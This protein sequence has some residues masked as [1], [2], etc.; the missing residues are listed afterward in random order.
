MTFASARQ[1]IALVII[2]V[3]FCFVFDYYKNPQLWHHASAVSADA[4][5]SARLTVWIN[6]LCCSDCLSDA[7]KALAALPGIDA[8]NAG[9][10][11][12]LRTREQADQATTPLPDY[13]NS[14]ELAVSDADKL[15][16]VAIDK[17]LRDQG[18]V[19]GRME[20]SGIEHFRLAAKVGHLCCGMCQRSAH[21]RIAFL[22]S[23]AQS[24]QLRWLDSVS[25]DGK[26]K[27]IV[28]HARYL[29]AGRTVDVAEF[30][31]AL[32]DIGY[33]P[34][35]VQILVHEHNEYT[36]VTSRQSQDDDR[37][38]VHMAVVR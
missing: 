8:V 20:L 21:E 4:D 27:T 18:L 19:A 17:A 24:G 10:P 6:H 16:F 3:A 37:A 12:Q 31:V 29:Q 14:L 33:V 1:I 25:V 5:K 9:G 23:R 34:S 28:A 38:L 7:R 11:K 15:D 30:L 22:K 36:N 32:N 26:S 13:G 35:S 2:I